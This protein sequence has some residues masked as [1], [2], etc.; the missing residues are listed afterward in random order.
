[1]D[2][3]VEQAGALVLHGYNVIGLILP[4]A[5]FYVIRRRSRAINRGALAIGVI[6]A[7]WFFLIIYRHRT[8]PITIAYVT[9][10]QDPESPGYGMYDG[11]AGNGFVWLFGWLP[12]T[13]SLLAVWGISAVVRLVRNSLLHW[14]HR[15]RFTN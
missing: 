2:I 5:V 4:A 12:P 9:A 6:A 8:L 7:A 1:M 10:L 13:L 3:S 14:N 11:I 15:R